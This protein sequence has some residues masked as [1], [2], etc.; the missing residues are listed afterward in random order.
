MFD[1]DPD[2]ESLRTDPTGT[3]KRLLRIWLA[4]PKSTGT[5]YAKAYI[6]TICLSDLGP[7]QSEL[8]RLFRRVSQCAAMAGER[9]SVLRRRLSD[10]LRRA[11]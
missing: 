2:Y 3:V 9:S 7:L 8:S 10:S 1:S 11:I 4:E 6:G 5:P